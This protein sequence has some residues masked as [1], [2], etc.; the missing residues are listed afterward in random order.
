MAMSV[1][2]PV[3]DIRPRWSPIPAGAAIHSRSSGPLTI[4]RESASRPSAVSGRSSVTSPTRGTQLVN[5]RAVR[6]PPIPKGAST[7]AAEGTEPG[8]GHS[9]RSAPVTSA[10]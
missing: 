1:Y 8:R 6:S 3:T 9:L 10:W 5:S 2:S 7:V 4:A